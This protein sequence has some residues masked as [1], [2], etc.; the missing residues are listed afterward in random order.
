MILL[1]VLLI[2][3]PVLVCLG[4]A[5]LGMMVLGGGLPDLATGDAVAVIYAEG[6]IGSSAAG[7]LGSATGITPARI[8]ADLR[9]A[10]ADPS[11]K[12]VVLRINS[13]GG[14]VVASNE[15]YKQLKDFTKP[16]VVS[17]GEEAASGGYYIACASKWIVANPDTLTGSIG[18]ITELVNADE[19][20]KKI[21]VQVIV[22]KTGPN[23]DIGSPFRPMTDDEKRLWQ[24]VIDQAFDG[25]V[26][27]V[28]QGRSLPEDK[29]RQI[30]DGRV[31]SGRQAKE[32]GLVDQLG[33]L[34]DAVNKAGELGSIKGKPRVVEYVHAPSLLDV[35]VGSTS[36]APVI[37]LEQLLGLDAAPRLEY[38]FIGP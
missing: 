19:L 2:G 14:S 15:I 21:G 32:L 35:L 18:V 23:K 27:V 17:M 31:Y 5:S 10:A 4:S 16:I 34:D 1:L 7:S 22:I 25:F 30:G 20:I 36:R 29:V 26:Q 38:R 9:R 8:Q 3:L 24:A 12:A 28:A 6:I 37:S 13:P 11:V 33:Y